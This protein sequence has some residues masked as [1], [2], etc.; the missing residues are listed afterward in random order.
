MQI[1]VKSVRSE[2]YVL[3]EVVTATITTKA[4]TS[5]TKINSNNNYYYK[6]FE[7]VRQFY[8]QGFAHYNVIILLYLH[9][10]VAI[11]VVV[12]FVVLKMHTWWHE[13]MAELLNMW[14]KLELRLVLFLL[15]YNY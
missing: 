12:G 13:P 6:E 5:T 7:W 2:Q 10:V 1:Q 8:I 11:I 9:Y 4:T 14:L 15:L 3:D